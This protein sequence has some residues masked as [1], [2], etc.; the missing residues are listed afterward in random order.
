MSSGRTSPRARRAPL[1]RSSSLLGTLKSIVAAPLNWFSTPDDVHDTPGEKRPRRAQPAPNGDAQDAEGDAERTT[2]R[3]RIH[4][5]EPE[6]LQQYQ[7]NR[8]GYLDPPSSVL[9]KRP[10]L[11]N[12]VPSTYVRSSTALPFTSSRHHQRNRLSLSPRPSSVHG[13]PSGIARTQSMDPP[14]R[15][16]MPPRATRPPPISRDASLMSIDEPLSSPLSAN[17][18]IS[19]SPSRPRFRLRTSLTPQPSGSDFG[20]TAVRRERD[21]SEPP[22][23]EALMENPIFV[24]APPHPEPIS[25]QASL[26]LGSLAENRRT[27]RFVSRF[28]QILRAHH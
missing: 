23:L 4:S 3:K 10:S 13:K 22:P 5:P 16:L 14:G 8:A 18:D 26:T 25:R 9:A 7:P 20:P 27:V 12:N 15:L 1:G 19:M 6:P 21:V 2:K 11:P 28:K 24:K 17:E